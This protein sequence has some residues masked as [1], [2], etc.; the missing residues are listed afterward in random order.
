MSQNSSFEL[1]ES[2]MRKKANEPSSKKVAVDLVDDIGDITFML[3]RFSQFSLE[4][5]LEMN[6]RKFNLLLKNAKADY[7]QEVLQTIVAISVA[8]SDKKEG[9]KY[10]RS[11]TEQIKELR[12]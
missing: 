4:S 1:L 2:F 12:K 7:Y 10:V 11:L 8:N 3:H 9:E 6:L 5:L